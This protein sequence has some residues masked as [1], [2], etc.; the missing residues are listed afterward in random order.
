MIT[1]EFE[2]L[3]T[4]CDRAPSHDSG[5]MWLSLLK[6]RKSL[7]L[8]QGRA[9]RTTWRIPDGKGG[10]WNVFMFEALKVVAPACVN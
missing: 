10:E 8:R 1:V 4:A 9:T 5:S 6:N 2:W 3:Q 7:E